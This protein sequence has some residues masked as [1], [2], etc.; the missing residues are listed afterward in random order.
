LRAGDDRSKGKQGAYRI[1]VKLTL[2]PAMALLEL[3]LNAGLRFK[4]VAEKIIHG[5]DV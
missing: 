2:T 3:E 4:A 1:R 5:N